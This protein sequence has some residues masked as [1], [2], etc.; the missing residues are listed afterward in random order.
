MKLK[1][2]DEVVVIAGKDKGKK[3]KVMKIMSKHNKIVVEKINM[4]TKHIKKTTE[5]AGEKIQFEAPLDASNVMLVCPQT[6]KPTRIGY[7]KL[8]NGKKIR[9]S[10]KSG[11][12]IDKESSTTKKK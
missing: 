4:R 9:I 6:Q 8:E 5:R 10:K 7:K 3:G 12:A 11:E 1:V 2:N